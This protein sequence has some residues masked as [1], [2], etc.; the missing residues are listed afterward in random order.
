MADV[1]ISELPAYSGV[2]TDSNYVAVDDGTTTKKAKI[3]Q[4]WVHSPSIPREKDITQYWTDGTLWERIT[5]NYADIE[6]GDY[7]NM[8]RNVTCPNIDSGSAGGTGSQYVTVASL[9]G[10]YGNGDGGDGVSAVTYN[11][12]VMIP[13]QGTGGTQHFGRHQMNASNTTTGGY[14]GSVMHTSVLGGVAS[15]G[16]V[17]SGATVN[18]QLRYIFGEHLKTIRE[19]MSNAVTGSLYNRFGNAGGASSGWAWA[20]VQSVLMTEAEVYGT[21]AWSASGYD[22]GTGYK[23]FELFANSRKAINNRSAYYWLRDVVSSSS[24]A[25]S[26]RDGRANYA[27]ASYPNLYVRPRFVLA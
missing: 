8:G 17:A 26:D 27:G 5:N 10:L 18:Q 20:S 16:S 4:L 15:T 3:S 25:L 7:I 14:I 9:G 24:F 19:F 6:P 12:L 1:F 22:I 21:I 2:V 11:H 13:G 23:Q